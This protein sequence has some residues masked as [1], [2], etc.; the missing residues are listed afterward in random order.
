MLRDELGWEIEPQNIALTNGSQ[1]AF[2]YLFNLFAGRRADGTTRK[3]LFPLTPEYI[4]YADAGLEE[5]LFVATRP[6]IE[7]LPEGQFKYHVDFEHLQV[8]EETGMIC[9]S[10][11][12]NPTGNVITDEELIKLDALANQHGVPLVIDNA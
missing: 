10:R 7:L 8:T 2:F 6:N 4:G 9:V 11:P 5:D 12:T 3:V 1:S